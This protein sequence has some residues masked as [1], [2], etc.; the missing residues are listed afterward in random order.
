VGGRDGKMPDADM[1]ASAVD[2]DTVTSDAEPASA[3]EIIGLRFN[4]TAE[5]AELVLKGDGAVPEPEVFK[6]EGRVIIDIPDVLTSVPLPSNIAL[7]V[8]GIQYRTEKEKLRFVIDMETG[9]KASVTAIDDE[10]IV[11]IASVKVTDPKTETA[12]KSNCQGEG[13]KQPVSFDMQDA[14]I[15]AIMGILNYDMTGCNIVVN[16]DDVKGKK[17]TMKLSNV[18]WDQALDIIL[19][20][21]GL[22]KIVDGNVVRVVTK[23]TYQEEQKAGDERKVKADMVNI[24]SRVFPVNYA[25]VDKIKDAIVKAKIT[26]EGNISTDERTRSIIVRDIPERLDDIDK[27]I[28]QTLDK[29]TRQVLIEARIVEVSKNFNNELGIQWSGYWS[30]NASKSAFD[31]VGS[32]SGSAISGATSVSNLPG[33]TGGGGTTPSVTPLSSYFPTLINLGTSGASTGAFTVGFLN[34]AR[35]LG[36]DLRISALE[37]NGKGRIISNPKIMTIDNEQATIKNGRKIPYTTVGAVGSVP[38]TSWVDAVLGLTVTPHVGPDK[39]ILLN[40]QV[41]KDSADFSNTSQGQPS[42]TTNEASTQ[43]LIKDGETVVMG[44]I[45]TSTE[46]ESQDNVPGI[47]KIPILGELFKRNAKS[48]TTDELLIFITPRVIEQ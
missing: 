15:V 3:E 23:S 27:L 7:P 31:V 33:A 11:D 35:T 44:G 45:L 39:T 9:A 29:P 42:I 17:I 1:P 38:N 34:A 16:P 26:S 41:S 47:S 37:S 21:Y 20:T 12:M 13:K 2:E 28:K 43:V 46:Q 5:G 6:L 19:K 40:I 36:L 4:R 24:T 25:K 18:P 32:A 48:M 22:E 10:L 8:K 30:P 14:D